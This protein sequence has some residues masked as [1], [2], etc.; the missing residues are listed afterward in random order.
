MFDKGRDHIIKNLNVKT[1]LFN[2]GKLKSIIASLN[3]DEL[4]NQIETQKKLY[5][6]DCI[7]SESELKTI[8]HANNMRRMG[9]Y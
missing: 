6:D 7:A 8:K 4:K 2:K 5:I 9:A 1:I 3:N